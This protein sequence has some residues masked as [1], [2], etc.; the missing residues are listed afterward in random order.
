MKHAYIITDG[1]NDIINV[2]L[3]AW[4]CIHAL[5]S[6]DVSH[7]YDLQIHN[8]RNQETVHTLSTYHYSK[9]DNFI[10]A[11]IETLNR[12]HNSENDNEPYIKGVV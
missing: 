1:F 7:D 9:R 5:P 12:Y 11:C 3:S 8:I 2:S 6:L 4:D 10:T